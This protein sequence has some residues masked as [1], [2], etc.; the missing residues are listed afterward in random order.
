VWC[1]SWAA[2]DLAAIKDLLAL[3]AAELAD[4]RVDPALDEACVTTGR[5]LAAEYLE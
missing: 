4:L 1:L 5:A 2:R 3:S